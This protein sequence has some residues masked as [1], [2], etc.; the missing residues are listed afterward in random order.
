MA[1][2]GRFKLSELV[3]YLRELG[4]L[5]TADA[6]A[7]P[8]L[9][10]HGFCS[11]TD[12]V[13]GAV[14][15]AREAPDHWSDIV[16]AVVIAPGEVA[17]SSGEP[18]VLPVRHPRGAF[19]RALERFG[20]APP[21]TG[22]ERTAVVGAD[23]QL[24]E[25]VYVGH[26]SVLGD[27]VRVGRGTVIGANVWIL[28]GCVIGARCTIH[29]GV[30]IGADGF[31][32]ERDARGT[33]LKFPQVGNVEIGDDVEIGANTCV[34][35]GT[36]GATRI[37]NGAKIDNLCHI[38]HNVVVGER[39][40][41]IA[42]SMIGGSTTL[43]ADSYVAPGAVVRNKVTVAERALVGLGA[44]VIR[45]VPSGDVVA[46]VPARTIRHVDAPPAG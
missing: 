12:P 1:A 22:V 20:T 35:R 42:L 38:A 25:N 41:V 21:P 45:D 34:D 31:G 3:A 10:L 23:C 24:A 30:V 36:L 27:S 33:W 40:M 11:L 28:G 15:W 5:E 7:L 8:E 19:A 39:A 46:G 2:Q 37:E 13:P 14:T 26:H 17:R 44:V 43:E 9:D 4:E 16:A 29:P 6:E 32:F 18:V